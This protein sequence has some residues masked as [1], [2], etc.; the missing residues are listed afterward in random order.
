MGNGSLAAPGALRWSATHAVALALALSAAACS[1]DGDEDEDVGESSFGDTTGTGSS[2]GSSTTASTEAS[3]SDT[4]GDTDG[5]TAAPNTRFYRLTHQQWTNTVR[6]LFERPVAL[7]LSTTFR[8]DARENGYMFENYGASLEV[9]QALWSDYRIAAFEVA[10]LAV[11]D[12]TL[13]AV[14]MPPGTPEDEASARALI[15]AFGERAFRRPLTPEETEAYVALFLR[16]PTLYTDV[17]GFVAGVRMVIEAMLQSPHFLYRIESSADVIDGAIP[18]SEYEVASR[19]SYFLWNSMPDRPLLQAASAGA[20]KGD[21]VAHASRMLADPRAR[22][23]VEAFHGVLFQAGEFASIDRSATVFP[24]APADLGALATEE[25]YRFVGEIIYAEGG[26]VYE[27]LTSSKSFVN[28]ETAA[29]YGVPGTFGDVLERVELPA[30]QRRGI[31][32]QIGFL[33]S[34]ASSVNPDP[35]HR[36]KFVAERLAC[37]H[38]PAPPNNIPP[39]P[40]VEGQTNRQ[41][42]EELTEQPESTCI[43]CHGPLINPFGFPFEHYDAVAAFRMTDNGFPVDASSTVLLDGGTIDV[44]NPFELIDAL[45]T[46]PSVHECYARHWVEYAAGRPSTDADEPLIEHLGAASM[47]EGLSV[48]ELLLRLVTSPTFQLRS[49]QELNG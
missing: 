36:G 42:I 11:G 49:A 38:M 30:G 20:L 19:L 3:G 23:T 4:T 48:Q 2:T 18:L 43:G 32:T 14:V 13:L 28:A 47:A 25:F 39:L 15:V 24:N 27:L 37:L 10:E 34:N 31:L 6:D 35:I 33:A 12:P 16:A 7:P 9:D 5:E 46:S 44:A 26:G 17:S 21:L 22:A 41:A 8:A 29:I 40:V 1:P 45:A